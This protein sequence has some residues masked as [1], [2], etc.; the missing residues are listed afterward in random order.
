MPGATVA[1]AIQAQGSRAN[2]FDAIRLAAAVLVLVSHAFPLTA[3][4]DLIEP[5]FWLTSGQSTMGGLAVGVF[6]FVSGMLITQSWQQS[7]GLGH[8]LSKRALRLFPA[9]IAAVLVT[10]LVLGPLMTKL[11]A[12]VY[13]AQ[14]AT[15]HY[16]WNGILRTVDTLPGV[17]HGLPF[18]DAV[19]GSLWTLPYEVRCY[20][21]VAALGLVGMLGWRSATLAA[22]SAVILSAGFALAAYLYQWTLPMIR[23]QIELFA[24]FGFGMVVWLLRDRM[25]I[26]WRPALAGLTLFAIA[27]QTPVF[28]PLSAIAVALIVPALAYA[29][30]LWPRQLT[31]SG[32]YSYGV[33][34]Y[35]FPLQQM[36]VALG[37]A[38]M[39]WWLNLLI[40]LPLTAVLAICSWHV[41]ERPALRFKIGHATPVRPDMLRA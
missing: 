15:W 36:T 32:D 7:R 25:P 18:A 6:F 9:L 21:L 27:T 19:N 22:G 20:L 23:P 12:D 34:L 10:V 24:F 3:G 4:N 28:L 40:A 16:L 13:F 8:F 26:G 17:F 35:A 33:Y 39:S 31:A 37:P 41:I 30:A 14:A 2:N 11:P 38:E 1:S 5:L 29:R